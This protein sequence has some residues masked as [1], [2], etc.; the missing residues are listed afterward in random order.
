MLRYTQIHAR[1]RSIAQLGNVIAAMRGVAAARAQQSRRQLDSVRMYADIVADAISQVLPL[2]PA[3][4]VDRQDNN[5]D[6]GVTAL[7]LFGAEHGFAG[8]FSERVLADAGPDIAATVLLV[9]GDRALRLAQ[10]RGLKPVWS[11]P[12]VSQLS[13]APTLADRIGAELYRHLHAGR[14]DRVEVAYARPLE[15]SG[16]EVVR[17]QLLPLDV[18]RFPAK[19]AQLAPLLNLA[20][21]MLLE[22]LA[23]EYLF[24]QLNESIVHSFAAENL[25]RL[26]TMSAAREN[27]KQRV[28]SLTS[29]EQLARQSEITAEIVEL[30]AGAMSGK[31]P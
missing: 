18:A 21:A 23:G 17:Q 22:R 14:I 25:A 4:A 2:A 31:N 30:A 29:E 27:I 10:A 20:P 8:A 5:G 7:V 6:N 15:M 12:M 19:D 3:K 13:N 26:Q 16:F 28:A 11:A 1:A 24:A 9:V